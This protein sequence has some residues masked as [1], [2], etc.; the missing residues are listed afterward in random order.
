MQTK[1]SSVSKNIRQQT[2]LR[3]LQFTSPVLPIGS[4]AYSQGLERVVDVAWVSDA[5][6]LEKW[7]GGL[8]NSSLKNIDIPIMKRL[9]QAWLNDDIKMVRYWNTALLAYRETSEIRKEELDKGLAMA[10][11]LVSLEQDNVNRLSFIEEI[12]FLSCYCYAS[13]YWK[14]N[15]FDATTA[16][17]WGW[18]ENQVVSAIKIM[19]LGQS[20]GQKILNNLVEIIPKV[21]EDGLQISDDAIGLTLPAQAIASAQHETQYA[22]LFRS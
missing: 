9:Y 19:P 17:I 12:S 22:R 6:S 16:Y 2:L 8:M 7:F 4:Y 11:L 1:I 3:L 5:S 18:L 21:V 10:N 13:V 14:I 20:K 15:L